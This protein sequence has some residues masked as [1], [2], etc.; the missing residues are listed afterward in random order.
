MAKP[1]K[2]TLKN[3]IEY[4]DS[5]GLSVYGAYVDLDTGEAQP[6][7]RDYSLEDIIKL[8]KLLEEDNG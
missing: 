6:G 7:C 5:L 3:V 1:R 8:D 4:L 2:Q